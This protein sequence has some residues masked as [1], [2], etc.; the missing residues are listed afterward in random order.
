MLR[1]PDFLGTARARDDR[2]T[3]DAAAP[4]QCSGDGL[5]RHVHVQTELV[6]V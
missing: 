2:D 3:C 5:R 1:K 6:D 4:D